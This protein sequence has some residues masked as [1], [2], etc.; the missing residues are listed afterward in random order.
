MNPQPVKSKLIF[1]FL[2]TK[3]HGQTSGSGLNTIRLG[4]FLNHSCECYRNAD[5]GEKR[6][7]LTVL[8]A[9]IQ[10]WVFRP[11]ARTPTQRKLADFNNLRRK[12]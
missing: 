7:N 10:R 12:S 11:D 1:A 8:R 6:L 5:D 9:D 3:R 2:T 4:R